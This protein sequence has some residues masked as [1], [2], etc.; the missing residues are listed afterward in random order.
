MND[1]FKMVEHRPFPLNPMPW[2][3]TQTWKDVLFLH[4]PVEE[5]LLRKYIPDSLDLDVYEGKAWL[6]FLPF[7]VRGMRPRLMPTLPFI[8]SFLELNVRTYVKY[9]G[10]PGV[11]F[12]S[13][14]ASK[15][16]VVTMAKIGYALPYRYAEMKIERKDQEI[17]LS[18]DRKHGKQSEHFQCSYRPVSPVYFS[19]EGSLDHWLTERYCLWTV[20][21]KNLTRSDIHHTKWELQ[22]ADVTLRANTMAGFLPSSIFNT[23]PIAHYCKSKQAYFWPP[24]LENN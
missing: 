14:D 1:N 24:I 8:G 7:E 19:K 11:Y 22:T 5:Q 15:L 13:L 21:G 17:I 20:R 12:F 23:E 9:K 6:G 10:K 18:S 4:W 16:A 2:I 3:M